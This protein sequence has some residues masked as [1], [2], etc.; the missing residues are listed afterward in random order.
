M[1]G[2]K[3]LSRGKLVVEVIRENCE[4]FFRF[5][6]GEIVVQVRSVLLVVGKREGGFFDPRRKQRG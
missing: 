5:A 4:S 1:V 3:E 2:S 6:S